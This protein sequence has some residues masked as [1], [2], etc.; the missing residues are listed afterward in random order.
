MTTETLIPVRK[1]CQALRLSRMTALTQGGSPESV[2]NSIPVL[3]PAE[4]LDAA[5][6]LSPI[7]FLY[8]MDTSHESRRKWFEM[9]IEANHRDGQN[10][11]RV[12][13]GSHRRKARIYSR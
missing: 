9:E 8:G 6:K 7:E 10:S 3:L 1:R 2:R 12:V 5:Y 4:T 13:D 11:P